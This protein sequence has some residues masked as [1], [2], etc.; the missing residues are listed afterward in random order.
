MNAD[1]NAT[2]CCDTKLYKH[3]I[4]LFLPIPQF[5]LTKAKAFCNA[6]L[7]PM[8]LAG[9]FM[10]LYGSYRYGELRREM[11]SDEILAEFYGCLMA[12]KHSLYVVN[13]IKKIVG[14]DYNEENLSK[15]FT[16]LYEN[17]DL[18]ETLDIVKELVFVF[19]YFL[20]DKQKQ[21]YVE[22]EV[23]KLEAIK[24]KL[25]DEA[26]GVKIA[27]D[28]K[29]EK[30][31]DIMKEQEIA[32]GIVEYL[33]DRRVLIGRSMCHLVYANFKQLSHE[34]LLNIKEHHTEILEDLV[35]GDEL[36]KIQN[37]I[38]KAIQ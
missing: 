26:K 8:F 2:S 20:D 30:A 27:K 24:L 11:S 23:N 7:T 5:S 37:I 22:Q 32:K 21:N 31:K 35:V 10:H 25:K 16:D 1:F 18:E 4:I 12:E 29:L 14:K 17:F 28:R 33:K 36:E 6:E 9:I 19:E 13:L 38:D 15:F 3:S 34:I